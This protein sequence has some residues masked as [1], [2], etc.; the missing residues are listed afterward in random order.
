MPK[1]L[2]LDHLS[3]ALAAIAA[4]ESCRQAA[5]RFGVSAPSAVRW[6]VLERFQ[7]MLVQL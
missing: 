7:A 2:S 1:A 6:R 4:G 3:R 5:E